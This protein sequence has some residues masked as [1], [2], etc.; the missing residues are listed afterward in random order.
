LTEDAQSSAVQAARGPI[1]INSTM[2]T[3]LVS[4]TVPYLLGVKVVPERIPA[5]SIYGRHGG[6]SLE[7]AA[8]LTPGGS[9]QPKP[10]D[11]GCH[12]HPIQYTQG[13]PLSY[14]YTSA[15]T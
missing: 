8:Q 3:I 2:P 4:V 7:E 11:F 6:Q 5:E 10:R 1:A 14:A 15:K 13:G 12:G 9:A